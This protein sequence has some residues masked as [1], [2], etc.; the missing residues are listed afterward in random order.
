[1]CDK[2]EPQEMT[3]KCLFLDYDGTISP[4][5]V[6]RTESKV[7]EKTCTALMQISKQIPIVIITTKDPSFVI[8]RTPFAHAWST[9]GG[10]EN[11]IR[12]KIL[13]TQIPLH[14]LQNIS[15]ALEYAKSQAYNVGIDIEEKRNS[16]GRMIAFCVDWRQAKDAEMAKQKAD[17]IAAYCKTLPL[18]LIKSEQP[19]YDVYPVP[20]NKGRAVT[21]ILKELKIKTGVMY[22]GD[23]E[24]DN[25]AFEI[26]DIS[27]AIIHAQT[28][29]TSLT[30]DYFVSFEEVTNFLNTLLEN[31]LLFKSNYSMIETNPWKKIKNV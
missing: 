15:I 30:S 1:M 20:I 19:F 16:Q 13:E 24:M 23:S 31:C 21:E 28:P 7:P 11:K 6:S 18:E 10:L 17:L 27:L 12:D 22:I 2:T 25:A 14:S 4:L 8:P 9:I 3:V 26:S 29:L 5:L